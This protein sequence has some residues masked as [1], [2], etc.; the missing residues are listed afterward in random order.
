MFLL[1]LTYL[2]GAVQT[3]T[4]PDALSRALV[5]IALAAQ[6]VSAIVEDRS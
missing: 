6:P 3:L 4:F 5:L 2:S 1:H